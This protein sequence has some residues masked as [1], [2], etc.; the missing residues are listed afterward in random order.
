[1][2]QIGVSGIEGPFELQNTLQAPAGAVN[3][4]LLREFLL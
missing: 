4:S 3:F 2:A 1:V